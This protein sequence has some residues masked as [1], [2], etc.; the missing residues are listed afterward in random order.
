MV[1]TEFKGPKHHVSK[2]YRENKEDIYN[3][4]PI[5]IQEIN[6]TKHNKQVRWELPEV[7]SEGHA[8]A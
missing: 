5:K 6:P 8:P 1:Y 7:A 2:Q 3:K 4:K